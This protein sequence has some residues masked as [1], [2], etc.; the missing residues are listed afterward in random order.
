[1]TDQTEVP[2]A[3]GGNW[4]ADYERVRS[5][6]PLDQAFF[7]ERATLLLGSYRRDD[8]NNPDT[9][10]AA[11][12]LVLSDYPR[13]CVEYVTDPRCGISSRPQFNKFPPNS[14]EVKEACD[15]EMARAAR[16]SQPPSNFRK[17]EYIPPPSYPGCRANVCVLVDSPMYDRVKAWSESVEA[18]SRDWIVFD[19]GIKIA[20]TIFDA[21]IGG[22]IK[23]G[24]LRQFAPSDAELRARYGREE[25]A[26]R[27]ADVREN[28]P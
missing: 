28:G 12:T 20:L 19:G 23:I 15:A 2:A 7:A 11:I 10:I 13:A 14:G 17:R 4:S 6:S 1:M 16:M 25:Q 22:Q 8:A 18:D 27:E 21:L 26:A 3:R 9:Y 5:Q 24:K